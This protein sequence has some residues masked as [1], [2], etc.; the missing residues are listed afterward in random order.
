VDSED[1][2]GQR[3]GAGPGTIPESVVAGRAFLI[4]WP[5]AQLGSLPAPAAFPGRSCSTGSRGLPHGVT[6]TPAGRARLAAL[7]GRR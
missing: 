6:G 5:P 1:S 2:R 4:A 3:H 7:R